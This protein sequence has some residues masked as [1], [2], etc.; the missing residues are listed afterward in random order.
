M[1]VPAAQQWLAGV[2]NGRWL[3]AAGAGRAPRAAP[4]LHRQL[5][6]RETP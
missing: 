2:V 3:R 1:A 4:Q 5:S 6:S